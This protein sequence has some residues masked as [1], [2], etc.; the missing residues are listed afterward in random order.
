MD[1]GA[2]Q[3]QFQDFI[4]SDAVQLFFR[5]ILIYIVLLWL[6]TAF[7][8]YR[9]M[10]QRTTNPIAP[11]LAATLIIVFTPIAFVFAYFLY[12]I[13]RPKETVSEA[14]ERALAEEAMLVEIESQPHCA[15][16][17]RPV[18]EDWI[19]C[20][21]CRNRLRRV[22][23]NCSRL[24]ELDWS[25]CAYCGKDFER[26][27]ILGPAYMPQGRSAM[28]RRQ[29]MPQPVMQPM[30]TP[31]VTQPPAYSEP[32]PMGPP[33]LAPSQMSPEIRPATGER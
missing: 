26:P 8:A 19:I 9:D 15:N 11:Y 23:P 14:N 2:L 31:L 3:Q 33:A 4:N 30:P 13:V 21:T 20:P 7:W 29:P 22:C 32:G 5:A 24:V 17:S 6:A 16:C 27:E 18:H 12:K 25:L 10:Q 1:L 28:R